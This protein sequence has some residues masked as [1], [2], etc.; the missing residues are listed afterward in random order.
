LGTPTL[1]KG[2]RTGAY[3]TSGPLAT[4][5]VEYKFRDLVVEVS[6]TNMLGTGVQIREHF[7]SAR[8]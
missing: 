8:D 6:A 7:V 5:V 3:L 2:E 4:A 1:S